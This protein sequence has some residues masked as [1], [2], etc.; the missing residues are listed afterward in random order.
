MSKSI[1][2]E[3]GDSAEWSKHDGGPMPVAATTII[4][5]RYRCGV[6]SVVEAGKRRW[7]SWPEEIG[8]SDWDIIAWRP[9]T[10]RDI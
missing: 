6:V 1:I 4:V 9:T 5:L 10:E 3:D 7:Q 2:D 8:P